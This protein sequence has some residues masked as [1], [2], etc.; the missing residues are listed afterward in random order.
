MIVFKSVSIR[1]FLSYGNVP[2][3]VILD[4]P[5]T[6]FISGEDL[7]RTESGE[8][9]NGVG[10]SAVLNAIAYAV[11]GKTVSS[12]H[13]DKLVNFINKKHME[14]VVEFEKVGTTYRVT[15]ARKMKVGAAGNYVIL[16]ENGKDITLDTVGNTNRKI[17]KIMGMPYE[18][19]VRIVAF[20]ATNTPFLDLPVRSH[21][22]ANQTDIIEELFD[23]KSLSE[24]ASLL[25]LQIVD[26]NTGLETHARRIEL[27][28]GEHARHQKQLVS[29]KRRVL[30]WEEQN[31]KE[32]AQIKRKLQRLEGVDFD[33]QRTLYE[34]LNRIDDDLRSAMEKQRSA[35]RKQK[36]YKSA[37]EKKTAELTHLRDDR[38][39]YCLQKY[40][41]TEDKI[42]ETEN[43]LNFSRDEIVQLD[44]ELDT[45]NASI[46]SLAATHKTTKAQITV[47]DL[48]EL[49]EIKS[50]SDY[51]Q[52]RLTELERATNPFLEPL[53]ELEQVKLDPIDK[54]DIN[55]LQDKLNHQKFLLKLLTKKDSFV[56]KILLD[57]NIPFL[58]QRLSHYLQELG[59]PHNVE[60]THEM[61]ASISMFGRPLDFG[62]LSNGQRARVNLALSFAFGDVLQNMHEQ[63]NIC[64]LD[65]VLDVGL[66]AVG[67]QKA[68]SML[69]RK[70]RSEKL[71][72]YI[73]SHR[74]ELDSAFDHK[75][76][77][78]MSKGFSYV[79]F[80][81][82]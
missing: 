41:N 79:K 66:D 34:E 55:K 67:V 40:K 39:P 8:G 30:N 33:Q 24:K 27:L 78:E 38:C 44:A 57:K 50:R 75:M 22:A 48:E 81:E 54:T 7:D 72:I 32:I 58:N 13:K 26:T 77:V 4:R 16:E 71:S 59:L 37:V 15:R 82:Q 52:K 19:F 11:Y 25:K 60:F 45:I 65:E 68:A 76:I 80:E 29:A 6:T 23:L 20:S 31:D 62:N 28:E 47:N 64:M 74:D 53:E 17:E 9:S 73:I 12:I 3:I 49:A 18:L 63:V 35:E 43:E 10:K 21:Y 70:A 14:V 61:T 51:Y 42:L 5:G 36:T 46:E 2:T 56:R 1:N 69:K